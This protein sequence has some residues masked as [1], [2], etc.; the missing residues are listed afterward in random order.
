MRA[1]PVEPV[2]N[3]QPTLSRALW[4][5]A[6]G[7]LLAGPARP[8]ASADPPTANASAEDEKDLPQVTISTQRAIRK[9]VESFVYGIADMGPDWEQDGVPRWILPVCPLVAGLGR[10]DAEFILGRITEI[11]AA[12]QVPLGK[13][14]CMPN[15]HILVTADPERQLKGLRQHAGDALYG[16][17][18][19]CY[20]GV[21]TSLPFLMRKFE[22]SGKPVRVWYQFYTDQSGNATSSRVH[23]STVYG[24]GRVIV[25]VDARRIS[26]LSR[27]QLA[28]YLAMV[29]LA[30]I[31]PDSRLG[32]TDSIL[33]LF[34]AAPQ[35]SR[36][37]PAGLS[38]WDQVFLKAIY[39]TDQSSVRQRDAI[40]RFMAA[41]LAPTPGRPQE[42]AAPESRR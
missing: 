23:L 11:A 29:G 28:D 36:A 16:Q 40:A 31:K 13:E 21:C 9:E 41:Q 42:D 7:L 32:G 34:D 27:Q 3:A 18:P 8:A 4:I 24:M 17:P 1:R 6:A 5:I 33:R 35:A 19:E 2:E 10:D 14:Q 37:S 20:D 39:A 26:G 12:A 38:S 30:Q 25:I 15:L 22:S